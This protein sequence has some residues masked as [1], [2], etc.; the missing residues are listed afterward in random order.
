MS[1]DG[2]ERRES[3]TYLL[4]GQTSELERLQL[5]SR[6][7]EPSGRRLL[8]EIGVGQGSRAVDIGC[9]VLGWLRLLSEWVGPDGEVVGTDIDDAMLA[10]A[11][12]FVADEALGNVVLVQD[13][14]FT[15]SLEASSFDLVHSRFVVGPLARGAEQMATYCSLTRPGGVVALE[16]WDKGSW[17]YNPPAPALEQLVGLINLAFAEVSELDGGRTHLDLFSSVG[18]DVKMRAEV[19]A[20]PPGHP[21]LRLPIQMTTGLAPRLAE[22]V[23]AEE[24]VRLQDEA[25]AELQEPG[26]WGTTFTVIQSWGRRP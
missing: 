4:A 6:V 20:L 19:L 23:S 7:W 8:S 15:C 11:Q 22:F 5:Q 26:R 16:D 17:H 12:Q 13:D 1:R 9:G 14:V 25:E 24:L 21:Y 2:E 3:K 10:A 18:I